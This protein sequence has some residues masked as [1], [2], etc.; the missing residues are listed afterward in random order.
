[1]FPLSGGCSSVVQDNSSGKKTGVHNSATTT[2]NIDSHLKCVLIGSIELNN[3]SLSL[4]IPSFFL[5]KK[6]I[7]Y[8]Y[9][10]MLY[11]YM[12]SSYN[13]WT[14]CTYV[15]TYESNFIYRFL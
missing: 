12:F 8:M 6:V 11:M 7:L 3:E 13:C 4:S 10:C 15:R 14:I 5:T 2:E 1:M 9:V